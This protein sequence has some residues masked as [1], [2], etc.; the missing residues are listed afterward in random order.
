MNHVITAYHCNNKTK[1]N[2]IIKFLKIA[3][4]LILSIYW[5]KVFTPQLIDKLTF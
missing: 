1:R 4:V 3:R 2:K 5:G